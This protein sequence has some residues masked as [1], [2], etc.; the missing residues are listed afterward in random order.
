VETFTCPQCGSK[1]DYDPELVGREMRLEERDGR[2]CWCVYCRV[3]CGQ[4]GH[5]ALV[6]LSCT[7]LP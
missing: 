5:E 4:C 1:T 2:P 3:R 7:A 6:L